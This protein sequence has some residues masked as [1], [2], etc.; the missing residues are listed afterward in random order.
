MRCKII[1]IKA[2]DEKGKK[3]YALEQKIDLT[4]FMTPCE[5]INLNFVS[6]VYAA[7]GRTIPRDNQLLCCCTIVLHE[8]AKDE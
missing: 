4:P 2:A 5:S 6:V 7:H 8:I 3:T 1:R